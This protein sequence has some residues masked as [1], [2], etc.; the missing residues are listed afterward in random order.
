MSHRLTML[1]IG[2]MCVQIHAAISNKD[3]TLPSKLKM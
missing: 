2:A 1:D 3:S